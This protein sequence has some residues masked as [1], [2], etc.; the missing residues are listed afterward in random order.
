MND[1][2]IAI[3]GH[4]SPSPVHNGDRISEIIGSKSTGTQKLEELQTIPDC[5]FKQVHLRYAVMHTS[6]SGIK[7]MKLL[8][9]KGLYASDAM[10]FCCSPQIVKTLVQRHGADPSVSS[11]Y[12]KMSGNDRFSGKGFRRL[13]T[14]LKVFTARIILG[15]KFDSGM[16]DWYNGASSGNQK[17]FEVMAMIYPFVNNNG[18]VKKCRLQYNKQCIKQ[19]GTTFDIGYHFVERLSEYLK[20]ISFAIHMNRM[21][22][23]SN[24][25]NA[26]IVGGD[27]RKRIRVNSTSKL[28]V[29]MEESA[30][31]QVV[32][33][34][35][36]FLGFYPKFE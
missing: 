29:F 26:E 25:E 12:S 16:V 15:G 10:D 27:D 19:N 28:S 20:M 11:F 32:Q 14:I 23:K 21:I 4:V 30:P 8:V 22:A 36:G 17:V 2:Q 5:L 9:S 35:M 18:L 1:Y 31:I 3:A 6:G 34:I 33:E 7:M 24:V 13:N